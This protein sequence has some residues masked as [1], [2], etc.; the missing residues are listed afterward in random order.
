MKLEIIDKLHQHC[1]EHF[2]FNELAN[3]LNWSRAQLE[4]FFQGEDTSMNSVVRV[5]HAMELRIDVQVKKRP[6]LSGE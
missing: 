4:A 6:P 3:K 2:S 5:A 1:R